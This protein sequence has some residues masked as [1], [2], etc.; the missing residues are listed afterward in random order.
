L[1]IH[2]LPMV[3]QKARLEQTFESWLETKQSKEKQPGKKHE[4]VDDVL[5][6]GFKI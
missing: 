3:L 6:M 1:S 5:V 4:Q 2:H